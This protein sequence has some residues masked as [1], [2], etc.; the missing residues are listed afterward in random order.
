MSDL[1]FTFMRLT[2][3][4]DLGIGSVLLISSMNHLGRV[5]TTAYAEDL[6]S[7]FH[8]IRTTFGGQIRALHRYPV[9]SDMSRTSSPSDL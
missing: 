4:C 3:G 7:A 6:V 1:V 9:S 2:R 5:G 8:D